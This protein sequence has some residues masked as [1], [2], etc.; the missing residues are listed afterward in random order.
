MKLKLTE[1]Q[2]QNLLTKLNTPDFEK[3]A[4]KLQK[5]SDNLARL[6]QSDSPNVINNNV[7]FSADSSLPPNKKDFKTYIPSN[8]NEMMHPLGRKKPIS[9]EFGLR[10]VSV[11]GKNHKGIDIATPSD[12]PIYAPLDGTVDAARDT[13]PNACGGFIQLNHNNVYTK[14][15]HL[16]Q[17]NVHQGDQVKKGQV[18]G[19]SGGGKNDPMRGRATGPHLHYEILNAGHIAMNPVR[20]QSNLAEEVKKKPLNKIDEFVKFVIKELGI[21]HPP[22]VVIT[23]NKDGIKTTA[24]YDYGKENKIMKIYGKNRM[25]VDVMRSAAHELVHH[26]Q[27]EDGKLKTPPPDIGGPIEDGA[28]AIAGRLIKKFALIDSTIYDE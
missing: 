27:W 25:M 7:P 24:N 21:K 26:K 15:C 9:S 12:S 17:I 20:V 14:F 3:F 11:G 1:Q 28:N 6:L 19:L 8:P 16:K 4:P 23:G 22:A 10:N 13:T 2:A 18:I 5:F